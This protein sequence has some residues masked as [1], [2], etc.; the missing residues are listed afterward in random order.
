MEGVA[1]RIFILRGWLE[2]DTM[3][4][5]ILMVFAV[6]AMAGTPAEVAIQ[7]A[8]AMVAK[9]RSANRQ[10]AMAYARRARETSDVAYYERA[11]ATLRDAPEG[12]ETEKIRVWLML[13]RH[14][15]GKAAEVAGGLAAQAPR[16]LVIQGYVA[17]AN[18]E[19][20]NYEQAIEAVDRMLA[21]RAGNIPG[22]TRAAYLRELLGDIEGAQEL[23]QKALDA[24]ALGEVEE[25]AWLLVQ[26]SHLALVQRD[27]A[28]A[29]QYAEAAL[30][31]FPDY[32]YGLG[33]LAQVRGAQQRWED[34][35]GLEERRYRAASHA[36]NL[37]AWAKALQSAGH[38]EAARAAFAQFETD[39]LAE[40]EGTDNANH[41]LIEYYLDVAGAPEK[42]LKIARAELARRHDVHTLAAN[43]RAEAGVGDP[44]A[45]ERL[46]R[47]ALATG[48]KDP[49]V[50][51]A[52][53]KVLGR[54]L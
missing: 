43:A 3:K 45:A 25:R 44:A 47:Q 51:E 35:A 24:T 41:E 52:A 38:A 18:A 16:D 37:F 34:A 11:E 26:L 1:T 49:A 19:L 33:A 15:F 6:C 23:M 4:L 27:V 12:I 40:S 17:D 32:H 31:T 2:E 36:E 21:L 39:A 30:A 13:G 42:A 5:T 28:R 22:L 14:E 54:L 50:L 48:T 53:Q 8:Q 29:E 7:K 20:G 10:L 46:A 9:D